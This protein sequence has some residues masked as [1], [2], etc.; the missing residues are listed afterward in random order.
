M[1]WEH[2][3]LQD[4]VRWISTWFLRGILVAF[5]CFILLELTGGIVIF[6]TPYHLCLGWA[7]HASRTLPHLISQWM[8]LLIPAGCAII[9]AFM[10]HRFIRWWIR[11]ISSDICW[12]PV[13]TAISM[14]LLLLTSGAAIAMSGITHQF[15]WL[16]SESWLTDRG[17]KSELTEAVSNIRQVMFVLME[18]ETNHGKYPDSLEDLSSEMIQMDR[19]LWL[20][21][22]RNK[23]REPLVFLKAGSEGSLP[24]HEPVIISPVIASEGRIAVGY[25]D[26]SVRSEIASEFLDRLLHE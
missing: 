21:P 11:S 24:P 12:R 8:F 22:T 23:S 5:A 2:P 4:W 20:Q 6:E 14:A 3:T 9:A 26:G 1:N 7:L 15:A 16:M 25:A 18:Y 17:R 13:H 10:A 19:V